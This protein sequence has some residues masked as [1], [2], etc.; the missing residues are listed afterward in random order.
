[1]NRA[2]LQVAGRT[3]GL[4]YKCARGKLR[5]EGPLR[6]SEVGCAA[7]SAHNGVLIESH[8]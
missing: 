1:M 6:A 7:Q 5:H 3:K 2:N 8:S 4:V